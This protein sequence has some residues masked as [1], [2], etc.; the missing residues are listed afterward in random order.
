MTIAAI[1]AEH[2]AARPVE[3]DNL[4]IMSSFQGA[5]E[6]RERE[7]SRVPSLGRPSGNCLVAAHWQVWGTFNA[8]FIFPLDY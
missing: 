2:P 7:Q 1:A 6:Q 4:T 8:G 3:S 5:K